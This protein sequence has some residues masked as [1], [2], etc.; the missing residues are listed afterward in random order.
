MCR[1]PCNETHPGEVESNSNHSSRSHWPQGFAGTLV[2]GGKEFAISFCNDSFEYGKKFKNVDTGFK[3]ANYKDYRTVNS[4]Y[5]SWNIVGVGSDSF[6]TTAFTE[7]ILHIKSQ[8]ILIDFFPM[9]N[10]QK[11]ANGKESPNH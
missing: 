4:Y 2:E 6:S 7:N 3:W 8:K 5:D 11:L 10:V 9:R 1:N